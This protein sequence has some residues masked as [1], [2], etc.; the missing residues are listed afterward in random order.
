MKELDLLVENYFTPALDATDIL[1]LVEQLMNEAIDCKGTTKAMRFEWVV[2]ATAR[3][4]ARKR[5]FK[6]L[7]VVPES[8]SKKLSEQENSTEKRTNKRQE[9]IDKMNAQANKYICANTT[10]RFED[11]ERTKLT[12]NGES[13]KA[14]I[15]KAVASG[16]FETKDFANASMENVAKALPAGLGEDEKKTKIEVKT[17]IMFGDKGISLKLSGNTQAASAEGKNT[18]RVYTAIVN[19]WLEDNAENMID[20]SAEAVTKEKVAEMLKEIT[21]GGMREKV[22]GGLIANRLAKSL[23]RDIA[24]IKIEIEALKDT[25]YPNDNKKESERLAAITKQEARLERKKRQWKNLKNY[26]FVQNQAKAGEEE[27]WKVVKKGFDEWKSNEDGFA[28]DMKEKLEELFSDNIKSKDGFSLRDALVDELLTGRLLFGKKDEKIHPGVAQYIL[29][30]EHC[31]TLVKGEEGYEDTI[32][33]YSS[34]I[35]FRLSAKSD[36]TIVFNDDKDNPV[37]DVNLGVAPTWRY[38]IKEKLI[39]HVVVDVVEQAVENHANPDDDIVVED[40][41]SDNIDLDLEGAVDD[42]MGNLEAELQ[43]LFMS[44]IDKDAMVNSLMNN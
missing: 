31:Y 22:E 36:R 29:T 38:D 30:P 14:A 4:Y 1:R 16:F 33:A 28:K 44:A 32:R 11:K 27:I 37:V 15:D 9:M 20:A 40:A 13:A 17:D 43:K 10:W 26:G 5:E 7:P 42:A 6:A 18:A 23:P 2:I 41:E 19:S 34:A 8:L 24:K 21:E 12:P 35:K 3:D 25:S 39:K